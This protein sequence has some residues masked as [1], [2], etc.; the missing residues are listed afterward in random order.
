M[1]VRRSSATRVALALLAMLLL[2]PT[3]HAQDDGGFSSDWT[4]LPGYQD[5]S[6]ALVVLSDGGV[7]SRSDH[8]LYRSDDN[9]DSWTLL[10]NPSDGTTIAADPTNRQV[11]YAYGTAGLERSVDG[12]V[13]W[14]HVRPA[15]A[16][17]LGSGPPPFAIGAD[18]S[19]LF[20][21]DGETIQRSPD[22]GASWQRIY[23]ISHAGSP[24][25]VSFTLLLAHPTDARRLVTDAGCYAG[26]DLGTGLQQTRDGGQ[27]WSTF[28]STGRG[29]SPCM[30]IGGQ[31]TQPNRWYL[32]ANPFMSDGGGLVLRSDDDGAT[33]TTMLQT[34]Q[35]VQSLCGVTYDPTNPD[36]VW[37]AASQ[38]PD[39]T[40]TGVRASSDGG[41]TWSY[42]GRQDIGWVHALA[43][44]ADGSALFAA[45]NEGIWRLVF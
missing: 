28:L 35:Q 2:A 3:G 29:L 26:R 1:H 23:A 37:V 44:A 39:P 21:G 42:L 20:L 25:T 31:G 30:L 15:P 5:G 22:A 12:G 38:T 18:P 14:Q 43:R 34:E 33:W 24:C 13:S 32:V 41:H 27:T 11:L 40:L 45:T 6:R 7:L 17:P 36:S 4:L 19:E 8:G 9:G 10:P 16:T